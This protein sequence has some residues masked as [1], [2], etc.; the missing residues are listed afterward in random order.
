MENCFGGCVEG[1]KLPMR[2]DG[3]SVFCGTGHVLAEEGCA[4]D[5][6]AAKGGGEK[7]A[8]G[9]G[10]DAIVKRSGFCWVIVSVG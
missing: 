9:E 3:G 4:A 7:I 1:R 10:E 6:V 8:L 2:E 5:I